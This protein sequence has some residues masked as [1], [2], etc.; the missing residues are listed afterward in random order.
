MDSPYPDF[1]SGMPNPRPTFLQGQGEPGLAGQKCE[2]ITADHD[3]YYCQHTGRIMQT[4][5]NSWFAPTP[6]RQI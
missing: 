2:A 5:H 6:P 1:M 4:R 3:N